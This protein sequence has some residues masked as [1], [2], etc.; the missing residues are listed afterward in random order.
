ME[1]IVYKFVPKT[2]WNTYLKSGSKVYKGYGTDRN[3]GH[4]QLCSYK[5]LYKSFTYANKEFD[6]INFKLLSVDITKCDRVKWGRF[7]GL[8]YPCTCNG[9]TE[10]NIL[11][12]EDMDEYEFN[13]PELVLKCG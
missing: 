12:I 11:S 6:K 13:D 5:H 8:Y 1:R 9:L 2:S 3:Y 7:N 4:V 10:D